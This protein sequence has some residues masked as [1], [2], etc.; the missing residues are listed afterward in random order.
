MMARKQKDPLRKL[1]ADEHQFLERVSRSGS[2]PASH[3]ARA[4][5]LLAVSRGH[6]Y[7]EAARLTGRR[8]GD[9]VALLVSRFNR[10]GIKAIEPRHGGGPPVVYGELERER[11]LQEARR[12]PDRAQDG[13]A[14]WTLRSL[15][16]A[17]RQAA[18]GLPKVSVYTIRATLLAAGWT[19]QRDGTW[20][21]TGRVQ[22][23]RQGQR[24]TV[25]DPDTEAKK[26]PSTALTE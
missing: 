4:K 20:C 18:D 15:Q 14:T 22:R 13:T 8:S 23:K 1:T 12:S 19:Y 26:T 5:A 25:V 7:A 24:V 9:A 6:T 3:V 11:I 17:L 10:E 2:A 16:R 21:E